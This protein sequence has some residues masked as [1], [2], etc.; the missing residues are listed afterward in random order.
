MTD[1]YEPPR[2][3]SQRWIERLQPDRPLVAALY[4]DL[5][6]HPL[7]G[8]VAPDLA[9][10]Y[11]AVAGSLSQGGTLYLCGNGGSF[12]DA[13]HISGEMLKSFARPRPL[14]AAL[15][16]RLREQPHGED[17][18]ANL[19]AGLRAHVLGANPVL[20]SAVA[21]DIPLSGIGYA[22]EL[23]A[24]AR[25]GD[26]LLG[27]STSGRAR[28]VLLAVSTAKAIGMITIGFTGQAGNALATTVDI[29]VCAP[30]VE[31]YRVQEM[32]LAL[33]H[34]LCLMV[35]AHFFGGNPAT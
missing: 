17:L 4:A 5:A 7:V 6:E 24:L 11:D 16:A 9:R 3:D 8:S 12:A 13:L 14:P 1:H 20:L 30:E 33:Y 21:N 32:H 15:Q 18:A 34:Q 23:N 29:P 22:Q 31:T 2:L 26:V 10:A 28:N 27:I 25:P 19:Q 35:E